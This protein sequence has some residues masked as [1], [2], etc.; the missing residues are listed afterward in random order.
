MNLFKMSVPLADP[1]EENFQSWV[2]Q[3]NNELLI[4]QTD[5]VGP[6][7]YNEYILIS[8][9]VILVDFLYKFYD[10]DEEFFKLCAEPI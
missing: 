1:E 9:E 6:D 5:R 4:Y 3:Q 2:S 10:A 7:G 8:D